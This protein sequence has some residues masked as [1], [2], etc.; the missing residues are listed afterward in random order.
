MS[1]NNCRPNVL[2][3]D[4]I[5]DPNLLN[6]AYELLKERGTASYPFFNF[7]D[8]IE[9]E[10]SAFEA[11]KRLAYDLWAK[12]IPKFLLPEQFTGSEIWNNN[13]YNG[14]DLHQHVDVDEKSQEISTPYWSSVIYLGPKEIVRGGSLM[15]NVTSSK[16]KPDRERKPFIVPFRYNRVVI[17][18]ECLHWV[19]PVIELIDANQ[20]RISVSCPLW[21][22]PIDPIVRDG[23]HSI[24]RGPLWQHKRD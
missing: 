22:L 9:D 24:D 8:S 4:D 12:K 11:V 14:D 10:D 20:P 5:M 15:L 3:F 16:E 18:Q 13:M 23:N 7:N 1:L 2:L 6:V 19:S 21:E 17:F